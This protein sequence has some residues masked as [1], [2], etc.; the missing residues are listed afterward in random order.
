MASFRKHPNGSW[1]YRIRYKDPIQK[2]FKEK[3][4]RGFNTKKEAQIAAAEEEKKIFNGFELENYP[5]PL[6][7]Y[8]V[9]WLKDY[10]EGTVR[11]NTFELHKRNIHNHIIPYFKDIDIKEIKPMLYQKFINYLCDQKKYSKRTV[12]I[13]H[14]TMRNAMEKAVILG[15]IEK[16]PCVGMEI[17]TSKKRE[18]NVEFINSDDLS[19]FLS[20]AYQYGYIYYIYFKTL[21]ST[22]MR[23]GE[24]AALQWTDIDLKNKKVSITKTLDFRAKNQNELFGDPKTFTSKRIIT[25]DQQL[26]NELHDLKKRQNDAKLVLNDVYMHDLNLVFSRKD[27]SPLPKSSLFNAFERILKQAGLPKMPI[28]ALRHTHTVL[29]LESGASMKYVQE[30]L[31]HKSIRVTSDIYSHISKKIDLDSMNKYE[32]YISKIME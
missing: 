9:D 7:L 11:K 5:Y 2:K 6:K 19:L 25:I 4:K 21:L 10:K 8:L 3:S 29:L 13:I 17:K 24:A 15:K 20:T 18:Y 16:N 32:E 26:A 23:K 1:E 12:E 31:G 14:G 28:H 30:R 27:G 22:G